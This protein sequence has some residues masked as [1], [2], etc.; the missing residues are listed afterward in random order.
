MRWSWWD[1]QTLPTEVYDEVV[2]FLMSEDHGG[3]QVIDWDES[4]GSE[5]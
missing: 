4:H 1:V 5:T 2:R 3:D